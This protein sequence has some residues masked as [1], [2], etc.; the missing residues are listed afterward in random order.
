[1]TDDRRRT[2]GRRMA[3]FDPTFEIR[4]GR[5]KGRQ[6]FVDAA[7]YA[8]MAELQAEITSLLLQRERSLCFIVSQ[9]FRKVWPW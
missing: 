1:M 3:D 5:E 8:P 9:F 2:P 7:Y 6:V 4:V